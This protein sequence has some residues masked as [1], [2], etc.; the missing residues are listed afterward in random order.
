MNKDY[1]IRE[2]VAYQLMKDTFMVEGK[3]NAQALGFTS[4]SG[5]TK[6]DIFTRYKECLEIIPSN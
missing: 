5:L 6:Q 2:A 3:Y 1:N 4:N